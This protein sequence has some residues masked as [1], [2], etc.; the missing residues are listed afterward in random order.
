MRS[1]CRDSTRFSE[2][3]FCSLLQ[4]SG[5]MDR[6]LFVHVRYIVAYDVVTIYR[7]V[8]DLIS[9][10]TNRYVFY[11]TAQSAEFVASAVFVALSIC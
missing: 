7:G 9:T 10:A 8:C 2:H 3:L 5:A 4:K 1:C 6:S 11:C